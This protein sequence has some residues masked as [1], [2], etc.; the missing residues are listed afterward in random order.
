MII[1]GI[2]TEIVLATAIELDGFDRDRDW[3]RR[4]GDGIVATVIA[5]LGIVIGVANS[6]GETRQ[7]PVLKRTRAFVLESTI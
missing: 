2:A 3:D 4:D 5:A 6:S 7:R 1:T